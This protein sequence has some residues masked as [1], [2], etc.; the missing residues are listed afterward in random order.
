MFRIIAMN[1]SKNIQTLNDPQRA[2]FLDGM[3]GWAALMVLGAHF[4]GYLGGFKRD[5]PNFW[6]LRFPLDGTSGVYIFFIIS[7]FAL[8]TQFIRERNPSILTSLALRR[9]PRLCIPILASVLCAYILM[10]TGLMFSVQAGTLTHRPYLETFYNFIPSLTGAIYYSLYGIFFHYQDVWP[11]SYNRVLWTMSWELFGSGLIFGLLAL[12]GNLRKR[13]FIYLCVGVIFVFA[14][15]P[16]LVAFVLGI[17]LAE[18]Y[19]H[20]AFETITSHKL[21]LPAGLLFLSTG[22]LYST[23]MGSYDQERIELPFVAFGMVLGV[24]ISKKIR[25]FF[26]TRN[27]RFLGRI[28]FPLYLTHLLVM[29]SFAS[30]LLVKLKKFGVDDHTSCIITLLVSIP[31]A[32][33]IARL[34][35]PIEEL[36]ITVSRRFANF[37]MS[38]PTVPARP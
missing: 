10:S 23:F 16:A 22:W 36:S 28:S 31:V 15:M 1:A 35:L 25:R 6:Y 7:G 37:I 19:N 14:Q 2:V 12:F 29:C 3:R 24:M 34:F 26:E 4:G 33:A 11:T 27:S 8:S 38:K 9:Y 18:L 5:D 30:F 13:Y 20:P 21:A 17:F 32:I